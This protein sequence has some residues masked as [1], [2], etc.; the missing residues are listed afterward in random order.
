MRNFAFIFFSIALILLSGCDAF[1]THNTDLE[2]YSVCERKFKDEEECSQPFINCI[3]YAYMR[4][5]YLWYDKLPLIDPSAYSSLASMIKDVRYE[6]NGLL[7][8][9]FTYSTKKEEHESYY[10]GKRYGMG[11]SWKRDDENKLFVYMVYPSSPADT[12][13]LKRGQQILEINGFT[14]EE[15]DENATHNKEH[16]KDDDFVKKTDWNDVYDAENEGEP[17]EMKLLEKGEEI[18]TTVYLGDYTAKSVLKST[19]IDNS[20]VKT[21]YIHF[22]AFIT[23]SKEELDDVFKEFKKEKVKELVLDMRYNGGGLVRIA[24]QLINLIAGGLVN[25]EKIIKILY[26]DKHSD[27]NSHYTGKALSNS[28]D[29]KKIAVITT[30][31]TASASEMVINSLEPFIKVAVIGEVTYGK[32]VGMNAKNICDQT[33]VPITFKNANVEDYGDYYH[34]IPATCGSVDDF[35]HDFGDKDEL[36]LKEALN[37]LKT[38]KCSE[39]SAVL[40][41]IKPRYL[42]ELIPFELKGANKMDYTF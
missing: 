42:E 27:A 17:V 16:A 13:G 31:G 28:L 37:Y 23:P 41:D 9:R 19:I 4:D 34:G 7:V 24:E 18:V 38:G 14:V 35:K 21:G 30:K 40:K 2:Y 39:S 25:N 5:W 29:L 33:I 1:L 20:G 32:P 15:L 8:D 10:A 26:N 3:G 36:S 12:A 22:K 6:E 11:T